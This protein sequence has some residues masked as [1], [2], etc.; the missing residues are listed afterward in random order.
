MSRAQDI[1]GRLIFIG[2]F[3]VIGFSGGPADADIVER[4]IQSAV[5]ALIALLFAGGLSE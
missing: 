4:L 2:A 5:C 1:A 3:A